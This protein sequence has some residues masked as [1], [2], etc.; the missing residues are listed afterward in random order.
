MESYSSEQH[1]YALTDEGLQMRVIWR[2]TR[3]FGDRDGP[4]GGHQQVQTYEGGP[5][6]V[7]VNARFAEDVLEV[8]LWKGAA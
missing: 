4:T 3:Y 5:A 7:G 6:E 2:G 1:D 8:L